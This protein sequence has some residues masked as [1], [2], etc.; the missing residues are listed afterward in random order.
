MLWRDWE[1]EV[2]NMNAVIKTGGKQY[3]VKEGDVIYVEK[4]GLEKDAEVDFDVLMIS[5]GENSR[6]GTPIVD[7][8]SVKAK[9]LGDVKG[10]KI[11]IF[12]YK[13]K[14]T[15][16]KTQGHRQPYTKLEIVSINA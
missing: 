3:S 7:G 14:K 10:E 16:R 12:K 13:S 9:V 1:E 15:Y 8:A 5:D 2:N 11:V 4:L 6:I